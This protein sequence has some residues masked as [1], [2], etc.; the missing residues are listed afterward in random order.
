MNLRN[1]NTEY[2][3]GIKTPRDEVKKLVEGYSGAKF[4]GYL[5]LEEA[6]EDWFYLGS[7]RACLGKG[8]PRNSEV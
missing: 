4:R 8:I 7:I 1:N 5:S 3:Y 2:Y 6:E